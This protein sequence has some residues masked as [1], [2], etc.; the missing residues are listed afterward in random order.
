M[1]FE[2]TPV[3]IIIMFL[4][5][6]FSFFALYS[7]YDLRKF[8]F[9]P[10]EVFYKKRY[11]QFLSGGFLHADLVHLMFNML[12]YYF[13]AFQFEALVGSVPFLIIYLASMILADVPSF[14]KNRNNPM[15]RSI[16]ASG[17]VSGIIFGSLL[18]NPGM[19]LMMFPIPINIPA[20][21]FAV[22][23][24]T[25]CIIA[26][27]F[28]KDGINHSAHLWGA[29]AGFLLT[30]LMVPDSLRNFVAQILKSL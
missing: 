19:S 12:T 11:W 9:V 2:Q 20:P 14:I 5:G 25:Y 15:Y 30:M 26:K 16:G 4:T 18:L 8:L 3:A 29:I 23:Y 27:R 10:Y 7:K 13:F 1:S 24:L 28:A 6:A 21:V 22:L 17:A